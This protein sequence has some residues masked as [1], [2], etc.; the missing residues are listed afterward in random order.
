MPSVVG[1]RPCV[2]TVLKVLGVVRPQCCRCWV[3]CTHSVI[4]VDVVCAY[5]VVGDGFLQVRRC[6]VPTVL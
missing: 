2:P 3:L 1:V 6:C 5:S 4:G